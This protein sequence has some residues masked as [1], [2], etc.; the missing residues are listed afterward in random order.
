MAQRLFRHAKAQSWNITDPDMLE[1]LL[2]A[3]HR[4]ALPYSMPIKT[5]EDIIRAVDPEGKIEGERT[6][7]VIAYA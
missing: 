2:E 6:Q 1:S 4:E 3:I 5:L 7:Q